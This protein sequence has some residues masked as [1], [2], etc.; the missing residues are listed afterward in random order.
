ML[1]F[2][3]VVMARFFIPLAIPRYPFPAIIAVL[4]LDTV[5]QMIF[6]QFTSLPLEGYQGYDKALDTYY[7]AITYLS[8]LQNWSNDCAFKIGR[9]LFYYRLLGVALFELTQLRALL[10]IFPN[11]FE[12]FFIFYEVIRL[13]WDPELLT[14]EKLIT[15]TVL[16]WIFIKLPQEYWIHIAKMDTTDL[17][18]ANPS[19]ALLLIGWALFLLGM[20]CGLLRNMPPMKSGFSIA[21]DY[22][23]FQFDS[24]QVKSIKDNYTS[25]EFFDNLYTMN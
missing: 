12:Y 6:Q 18:K 4:M 11:I 2:W 21:A 15:A 14:K 22:K 9:F 10:L 19:Y 8:T 17:I 13:K 23:S 5:D 3:I 20:A 25:K 7:L 1:V 24:P 16:I